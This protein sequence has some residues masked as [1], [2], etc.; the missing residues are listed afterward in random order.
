[1]YS[2]TTCKTHVWILSTW[3]HEKN[4]EAGVQRVNMIVSLRKSP[5]SLWL[6]CGYSFLSLPP[7][8]TSKLCTENLCVKSSE[9]FDKETSQ[10]HPCSHKQ[11]KI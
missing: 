2:L 6:D 10:P 4:L 5:L 8:K 7:P 9:K 11:A 1:M 3:F